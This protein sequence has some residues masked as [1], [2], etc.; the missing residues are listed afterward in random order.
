MRRL[1]QDEKRCR[2]LRLLNESTTNWS[3]PHSPV[4]P[5]QFRACLHFPKCA[6]FQS[7][8][9]CFAGRKCLSRIA[10]TLAN[11][12]KFG[13]SRCVTH[14]Q[15]RS[16]PFPVPRVS[17]GL[18]FR[19][20]GRA[21]SESNARDRKWAVASLTWKPWVACAFVLA[22]A[23]AWPQGAARL[24]LLRIAAAT[25]GFRPCPVFIDERKGSR[26]HRKQPHRSPARAAFAAAGPNYHD[27]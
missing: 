15:H 25:L 19:I 1:S 13:I 4:E 20:S 27:T 10:L 3:K 6:V 17:R 18:H 22:I 8:F 14:G 12:T 16:S 21:V 11:L 26:F 24:Q 23:S 2:L 7:N 5:F 9:L